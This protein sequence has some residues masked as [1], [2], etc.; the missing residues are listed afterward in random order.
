MTDYQKLYALFFNSITDA[1]EELSKQ[2]YGNVKDVLVR[3][4]QDAEKPYIE[5]E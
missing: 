4:Q 2:N 3:A 5:E 1:L